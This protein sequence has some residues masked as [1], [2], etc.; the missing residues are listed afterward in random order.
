MVKLET[1]HRRRG[2]GGHDQRP[3]SPPTNDERD[4]SKPENQRQVGC[5]PGNAVE[6]GPGGRSQY[7]RTI[8]LDE[9][10]QREIV[11][12]A[13]IDGGNQFR[14]HAVRIGT[15]NVIAFQQNLV[16]AADAHHAMAKIIKASS[17][18]TCAKQQGYADAQRDDLEYPLARRKRHQSPAPTGAGW[19]R[20]GAMTRT[21]AVFG[22]IATTVPTIMIQTPTQIHITNGFRW[23]RRIGRPVSGF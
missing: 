3:R 10:L 14:P 21:G 22:I 19:T 23:A 5:N 9:R 13:A 15:A 8:L 18:V 4:Q 7:R 17:L 16:A 11:V 20:A 2:I 12:V 1:L 6:S